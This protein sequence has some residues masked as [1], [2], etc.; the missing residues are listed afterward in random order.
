MDKKITN[1]LIIQLNQMLRS[2]LDYNLQ[3]NDFI[4]WFED[5]YIDNHES[6]IAFVE[7]DLFTEIED[8]YS[9]IGLFEPD[10]W[11][12]QESDAYFDTKELRRRLT[13]LYESTTT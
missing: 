2:V 4:S 7:N 8:I 10:Y 3:Y 13:K 9:S 11:L 1:S 12:R 5:W 6:L